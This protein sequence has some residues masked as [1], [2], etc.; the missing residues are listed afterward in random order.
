MK[1]MAY[2]SGPLCIA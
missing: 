2:F 1:I